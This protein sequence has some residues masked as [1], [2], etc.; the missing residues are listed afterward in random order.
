MAGTTLSIASTSQTSPAGQDVTYS[1]T[2]S[3]GNVLGSGTRVTVDTTSLPPGEYHVTGRA[4]LASDPTAVRTCD[5]MFRVT[6]PPPPPEVTRAEKEKEFREN[7]HDVFF[8]LNKAIIK[9]AEEATLQHN[10]QFLKANPDIR[11]LV[12]GF[13]DERGAVRYNLTLG[14]KRA[15]AVRNELIHLGVAADRI[16]IVTFG[17][18]AQI[19]TAGNETCWQQNRRVGFIMQP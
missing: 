13:A 4:Q 1:W 2:S 7:V 9:P 6:A 16:Q 11:I 10:A 12:D 17:H 5:V 15:N 18:D 3:G 14:E 19:C 8:D